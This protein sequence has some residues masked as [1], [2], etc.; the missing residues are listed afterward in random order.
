[1]ATVFDTSLNMREGIVKAGIGA[2]EDLQQ[3]N[4]LRFAYDFEGA[5]DT[6]GGMLETNFNASVVGQIFDPER[7]AE[8]QKVI[9]KGLVHTEDWTT[10]RPGLGLGENIF[11]VGSAQQIRLRTGAATRAPNPGLPTRIRAILTHPANRT[12]EMIHTIRSTILTRHPIA[13]RLMKSRRR[14][15][16]IRPI[17]KWAASGPTTLASSIPAAPWATPV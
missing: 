15:S 7:A 12:Q 13:S 2:L 17:E 11:D 14:S 4:P 6:W 1:V 8:T 3:L 9:L 10:E 5:K 16:A